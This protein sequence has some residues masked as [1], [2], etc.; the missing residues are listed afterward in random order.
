MMCFSLFLHR[1]KGQVRS[2]CEKSVLRW[3]SRRLAQIAVLMCLLKRTFKQVFG[4][5]SPL[6]SFGNI[7][8]SWWWLRSSSPGGYAQHQGLI[9]FQSQKPNFQERVR[10]LKGYLKR[11]WYPAL[12][13]Q[14]AIFRGVNQNHDYK[15]NKRVTLCGSLNHQGASTNLIITLG[16]E[17]CHPLSMKNW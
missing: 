9:N 13:T 3:R 14:L 1:W 8:K 17:G 16:G 12:N 15:K 11:Q 4:A 6:V 10:I 2:R 5:V 7:V